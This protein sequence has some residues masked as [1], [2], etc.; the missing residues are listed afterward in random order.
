MFKNYGKL[1]SNKDQN[2]RLAREE[3]SVA[4]TVLL[5]LLAAF[6]MID[7]AF[8]SSRNIGYVYGI[9]KVFA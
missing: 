4:V 5:D 1:L 8:I 7:H 6:D 9:Y 3:D 2:T